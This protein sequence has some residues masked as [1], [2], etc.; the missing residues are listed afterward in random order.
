MASDGPSRDPRTRLPAAIAAAGSG[1]DL[2]STLA[3]VLT[4]G[5][6]TLG[7]AMGAVFLQDPDRPGLTLAAVHGF[8]TDTVAG[9][10][11]AAQGA[12]DPFADTAATRTSTFDR[13]GSTPE[14]GAFVG[15]YLPMIV[16]TGGVDTS[17]G[18][19]GVGWP[20]PRTVSVEERAY[21][22]ALAALA[23]L[24]VDRARLA[25]TAA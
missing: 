2:D 5:V 12:G 17:L 18:V 25:S 11:L 22:E 19:I 20:A 6:E 1:S 10:S 24:A 15:A 3:A 14:R 21:L 8:D 23:G 9:L 16:T 13:Q 7:C 4:T